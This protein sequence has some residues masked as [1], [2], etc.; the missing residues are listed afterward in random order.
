[1]QNKICRYI[2]YFTLASG[3]SEL[4]AILAEFRSLTITS[5]AV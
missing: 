1:M 2:A 4:V 3:I 5:F